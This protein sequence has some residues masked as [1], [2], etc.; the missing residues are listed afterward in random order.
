MNTI[1]RMEQT[2]ALGSTLA[3]RSLD[4]SPAY[5]EFRDCFLED[6]IS[7]HAAPL[8]SLRIPTMT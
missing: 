8:Q 4:S 1:P 5:A 6:A 7:K 2:A 3:D